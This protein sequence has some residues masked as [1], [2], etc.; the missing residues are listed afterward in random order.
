M[1]RLAPEHD[2]I[3][4]HDPELLIA[5]A[6]LRLDHLVWDVHE[7]P[8]GALAVK[9]WL[10]RPLRRPVAG[11]R[12][13]A[14]R[15][16]ERRHPLLLAEHAYADRFRRE[17]VVVP[18]A[19]VIPRSVPAAGGARLIHVGNLTPAR[20]SELMVEGARPA[21][22]AS[23]G[24]IT[25][26]VVGPAR[27]EASR[28]AME[29]GVAEGVVVWHGF[30]PAE[31]AMATIDGALAGLSLLRDLPNYRGSMP[32][33]VVEYTAHGV[34]AITT[35]LPLARGI[36]AEADAGVVVPFDDPQAVADAA[37][38]LWRAPEQ[39]AAM[40]ERGREL[41]RERYDW[42]KGGAAFVEALT[43]VA[44]ERSPRR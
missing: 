17:H 11:A 8:A 6:G 32:T 2:V 5:T 27:D 35:P 34:P 31:Q 15:L 36:V 41:V 29:A 33:K 39:A 23:A 9:D 22:A 26:E 19:V 43:D 21:H 24:E 3:V 18:N 16:V 12:R 4:V 20:G 28:V 30:Q 7:D 13:A 14:E 10:P 42:A 37:L 1:R 38:R 44:G 25:L 40:G